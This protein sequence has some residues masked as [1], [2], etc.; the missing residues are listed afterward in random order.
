MCFCVLA[1]MCIVK[2]DGPPMLCKTDEIGEIVV[3]SRAGGNMYYG[4]HGVTK[5]T[6]EVWR[7]I[8]HSHT[9]TMLQLRTELHTINIFLMN[10]SAVL[11]GMWILCCLFE[12]W[13]VIPV[14]ASGTPIGEIPF[15]RSGLLGFVGPVRMWK[16]KTSEEQCIFFMWIK[17][18]SPPV[19]LQ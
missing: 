7:S 6:F 1:L 13:Q 14:N 4:L 17:S 11:I 12:I 2:P 5:N 3:N 9:Q 8:T 10:N 16:W 18:V 15:V 19:F